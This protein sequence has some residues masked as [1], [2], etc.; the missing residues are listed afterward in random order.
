MKL[1]S[2]NVNGRVRAAAGRQIKE[3]VRNRPDVIALQEI[4]QNAYPDWCDGLTTAGYSV[5]SSVDLVALPYPPP[6]YPS[7]PFWSPPPR[8]HLRRAYF[9]LIASR[10]PIAALPGLQFLDPDEALYAFPEKYVAARVWVKGSTIDLHNAHLPP[11]VSR[12]EIKVHAFEAI[13]RRLDQ[14]TR[15]ARILCG[16]FNAPYE[17][18]ST[19]PL[20]TSRGDSPTALDERWD[21]A[22]GSVLAHPKLID[23]YRATHPSARTFPGS[24]HTGRKGT[25]RRYDRIYF[26]GEL[27]A[28]RCKYRTEWLTNGLSDH[29]AVEAI[30]VPAS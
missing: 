10:H 19:G 20:P 28:S 13:R 24:H 21:K 8:T 25:P 1:L 17:E 7:P 12:G 11:G 29:A 2:W 23:A 18:D 3:V 30:L 22:E 16:D 4:R 15:A 27:A 14:R 9:N 26:S 5:V 6:K